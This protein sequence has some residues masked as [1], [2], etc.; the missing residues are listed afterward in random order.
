VTNNEFSEGGL[1]GFSIGGSARYLEK[2][3]IGNPVI[4]D[5][6][7]AVVGLDLA[8]PYYSS[9]YVGVDAWLGYKRRFFAKK[10]PVSFQLNVRDLEE[11]GGF[12]PIVANSDGTHAVYRIVQPRTYYFTTKLEF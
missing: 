8:H 10:Y 7:G 3:V 6:T 4:T 5:S 12:R 11:G 9:G 1:K 2:A